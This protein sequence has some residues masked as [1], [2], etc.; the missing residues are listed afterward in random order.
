MNQESIPSGEY[1]NGGFVS[2][3]AITHDFFTKKA[4]DERET[5]IKESMGF[6]YQLVEAKLLQSMTN[7]LEL[8]AQAGADVEDQDSDNHISKSLDHQDEFGGEIG[9]REGDNLDDADGL[10]ALEKKVYVQDQSYILRAAHKL[11]MVRISG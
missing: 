3:K 10:L 7:P 2:S 1:P 6:L 5:A 9:V 4:E 11:R 8:A